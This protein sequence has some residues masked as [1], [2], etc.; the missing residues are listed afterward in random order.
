MSTVP[1]SFGFPTLSGRLVPVS[2]EYTIN[3]DLLMFILILL[4][5]FE[6]VHEGLRYEQFDEC[7]PDHAG[8]ANEDTLDVMV[9]GERDQLEH[10][11]SVLDDEELEDED[12]NHDHDE[13]VVIEDVGEDVYFIFFEF[14]AVEE[15]EDLQEHEYVEEQGEVL[16]VL[17]VPGLKLAY[18]CEIFDPEDLISFEENDGKDKTLVDGVE[19]D[20]SPHLRSDDMFLT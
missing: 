2:L 6:V 12:A 18:I 7:S 13:E 14:A 11:A 8:G 10:L 9:H 4:E 17:F 3:V 20:A 5:K 16:S 1:A 19:D 15:V